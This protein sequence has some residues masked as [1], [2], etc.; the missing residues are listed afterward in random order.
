VTSWHTNDLAHGCFPYIP[1]G[2]TDAD[3]DTVAEPVS[4]SKSDQSKRPYL[5]F[6]GDHTSR[7]DPGR[8]HGAFLSGL[9]EAARIANLFLG[10]V[11][12]KDHQVEYDKLGQ[13]Y[14]KAMKPVEEV[15][16]SD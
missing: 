1:V 2:R 6:A 4:I 15:Y 11:D 12:A 10:P 3:Y 14:I 9:R 5:F 8:L 7:E 16:L 13:S